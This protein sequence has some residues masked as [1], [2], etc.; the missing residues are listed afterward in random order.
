VTKRIVQF[1]D[2]KDTCWLILQGKNNLETL[3]GGRRRLNC[4]STGVKKLVVERYQR[5][6]TT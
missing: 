4:E 2:F 3:A 1:W 5:C 6:K